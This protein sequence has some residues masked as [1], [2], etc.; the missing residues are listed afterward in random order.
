MIRR[1]P[2][3][4][5]FPYTTLFRSAGDRA[6]QLTAVLD[7]V[8]LGPPTTPPR[9]PPSCARS[10]AGCVPPATGGPRLEEHTPE[11]QVR[12]KLVWRP[13]PEKKKKRRQRPQASRLRP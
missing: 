8:R 4:P 12:Q 9:L 5:L 2:R 3:S 11:I 13:L 6:D 7:A 1:P 10:R